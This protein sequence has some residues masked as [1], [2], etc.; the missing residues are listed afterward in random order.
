MNESEKCINCRFSEV[1]IDKNI[2]DR[3][4]CRRYPPVYTGEGELMD[5]TFQQPEVYDDDWCG[6]WKLRP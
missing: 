2:G 1:K 5:M 6:E 3:W 4:F